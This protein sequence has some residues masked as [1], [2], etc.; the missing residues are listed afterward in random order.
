MLPLLG[1]PLLAYTF[2]QL[3]AIGVRR[4]ILSCGYL[5]YEIQAFFGEEFSGLELQYRIEPE[6]RGTG[7]GIRF[8]A[9]GIE[10]TFVAL[11]GD[12]LREADLA[13]LLA[14]HRDRRAQ[15]TLLLARVED[16]SRYG[17]VRV[18]AEGRVAGFLEKP[19]LEEIDSD[20]INAGLYIL[21][22]EVLDLI[23]LDRP[24]S[25]EREVFP[26]LAERGTL[27]GLNL[28]G[29]WLDVGTPESYIQAHHDLLS[30][31]A[32]TEIAHD[33]EVGSGVEFLAPVLVGPGATV[34]DGARVG[35]YVYVAPRGRIGAGARVED[36]VVLEG[37]VVAAGS[38]VTSSIVAAE[39]V[40]A[41][42]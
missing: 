31:R 26:T 35:P 3:R 6:P 8:A 34:E 25:I 2:D 21:E 22:P 4:A 40:V 13:Q 30:R 19:A 28:P 33:V 27:Y 37:A 12:T 17:L 36:A 15:A 24:V 39:A 5:P 29:Y 10:T 14:F 18:D 1:R 9:E 7:G 16:P 41:R 23:D 11:N 42:T 20:L 38:H 32:G